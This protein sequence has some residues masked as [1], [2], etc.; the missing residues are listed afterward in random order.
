MDCRAGLAETYSHVASILFYIEAGARIH[1]K[2]ACTQVKWSWLLPKGMNDVPYSRVRDINFKSASA[3]K[4]R[5]DN[6][7]DSLTVNESSSRSDFQS[8]LCSNGNA[9]HENVQVPTIGDINDFYRKLNDCKVK[10][11]A[12]SL[13]PLYNKEFILPSRNIPSIPEQFEPSLLELPY[14]DLLKKCF[15]IKLTLSSEQ[16]CQIQ[17]DTRDQA[18][19]GAFFR[20]RA[21]RIGASMNAAVFHSNPDFPSQSLIKQLCYPSLFQ[22]TTKAV[23]RG[24]KHEAAAIASYEM[25][26]KQSHKN[27]R[28][29]KCGLFTFL[30][31]YSRLFYVM[32]LLWRW[33]WG[34]QM[35]TLH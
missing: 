2:L 10:P 15:A 12:L 27:F 22:M 28:I 3:L 29:S 1:E 35:P 5:L 6:K 11:V 17:K 19:G 24:H 9:P 8:D 34:G 30:A 31:C 14:P 26:M 4:T 7:I 16:V 18:K 21:G 32:S 25:H 13:V 23:M 33:V 20:H